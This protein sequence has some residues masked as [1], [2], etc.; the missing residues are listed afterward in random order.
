MKHVT[1]FASTLLNVLKFGLE[2][3]E[4]RCEF[5]IIYLYWINSQQMIVENL[6]QFYMHNGHPTITHHEMVE[7]IEAEGRKFECPEITDATS[8][9]SAIDNTQSIIKDYELDR[10]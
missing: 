4:T 3:F 1:E 2:N 5:K 10:N 6:T 8:F 9:R 7:I